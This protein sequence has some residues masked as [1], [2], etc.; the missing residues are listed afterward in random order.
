PLAVQAHGPSWLPAGEGAA[1]PQPPRGQ[2]TSPG[3][4]QGRQVGENAR[5]LGPLRAQREGGCCGPAG[6]ICPKGVGVKSPASRGPRPHRS[7]PVWRESTGRAP[8][9]L[10]LSRQ[11]RKR[12]VRVQCPPPHGR[13]GPAP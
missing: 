5:Q 3:D 11:Q 10:V 6:G 8:A 2:A 7:A 12:R 1:R 13:R 9:S 4:P